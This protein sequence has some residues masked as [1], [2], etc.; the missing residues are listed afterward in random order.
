M[1]E[2]A[3]EVRIFAGIRR[4]RIVDHIAVHHASRINSGSSLFCAHHARY[5]I[6][7]ISLG[8][9]SLSSEIARMR[10]LIGSELLTGMAG[11]IGIG[12]RDSTA[13]IPMLRSKSQW[14]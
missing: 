10:A 1:W 8:L 12:V 3:L 6:G 7:E 4:D 14:P 9:I 11:D 13:Q 5:T 2:V